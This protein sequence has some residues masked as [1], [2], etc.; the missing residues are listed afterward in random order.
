VDVSQ[1]PKSER[2]QALRLLA[3]D[4]MLRARRA[5]DPALWYVPHAGQE[6]AH[7]SIHRIKVLVP[8]N[9]WGKTIF[10]GADADMTAMHRHPWRTTPAN[11]VIMVWFVKL[12]A[13]FDIVR[14]EL[15]TRILGSKVRWVDERYI[16]PDGS[17]LYLGAADTPQGWEKWMGIEV[18]RIY[19][20]E[21]PPVGLYREMYMR[22]GASR[23]AELVIGATATRGQSWMED[24]LYAPWLEFHRERGLSEEQAIARQLHPTI[25]CLPRGGHADNPY[26][27]A[28][29]HESL[30]ASTWS[31]DAEKKV[32]MQGG[33]ARFGGAAVFAT[34]AMERLTAEAAAWAARTGPT[35]TGLPVL[36]D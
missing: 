36:A 7:R 16:W 9:R 11:P 28:H 35:Q 3:M 23:Q 25:F 21:E 14:A 32:R 15:G 20:D 19:F 27:P 33:F 22:Q 13:Q 8:G 30:G 12:K 29:V 2:D 18:D 4:R 26:L 6:A 5:T 10:M 1:V 17:M 34:D 31:S 24:E